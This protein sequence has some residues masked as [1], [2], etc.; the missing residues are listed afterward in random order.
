MFFAKTKEEKSSGKSTKKSNQDI[1]EALNFAMNSIIEGK[2]VY[3]NGEELGNADIADKW[4]SMIKYFCNDRQ[5]I[6]MQINGLLEHVTRMDFVKSMIDGVGSQTEGLHTMAGSSQEMAASIEEVAGLAQSVSSS[7]VE[8]DNI[9]DDGINSV[10]KAFDFVK[11]SFS[12]IEL[13]DNQMKGVMER[14]HKINQIIGI[15]K[16]I[17]DQTNLLALNA[18]IEAARAGEQGRGFAVV[19]EEVKKLAEHT[20]KCYTGCSKQHK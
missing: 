14:T 18:A 11:T 20:K 13:I 15:V 3:L 16:G 10:S 12:E 4:N 2:T 17:A 5:Q 19:A 6:A 1:L 8:S 7:A 9:V